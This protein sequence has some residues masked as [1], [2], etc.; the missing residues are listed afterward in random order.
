MAYISYQ[1]I[2]MAKERWRSVLACRAVG[3]FSHRDIPEEVCAL[4]PS[5]SCRDD[6]D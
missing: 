4:Q 3:T 2:G 1:F 5:R 6:F